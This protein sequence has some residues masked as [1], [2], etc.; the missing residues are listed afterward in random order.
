MIPLALLLNFFFRA[1]FRLET[2]LYA[3]SRLNFTRLFFLSQFFFALFHHRMPFRAN[4]YALQISLIKRRRHR[5]RVTSEN[6][7]HRSEDHRS[8]T[9]K[10]IARQII[11][12]DVDL[13]ETAS[14]RGQMEFYA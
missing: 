11:A 3:I 1:I 5:K 14:V 13:L 9:S 6:L 12:A 7:E 4:R 2:F 8:P 10:Q